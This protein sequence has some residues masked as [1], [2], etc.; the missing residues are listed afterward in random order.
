[1]TRVEAACRELIGKSVE[2]GWLS[3]FA[4]AQAI[5]ADNVVIEVHLATHETVSPER[6]DLPEMT[7]EFECAVLAGPAQEHHAS[8]RGLLPVQ[9]PGGR[10][11][12]PRRTGFL[13]ARQM[14]AVSGCKTPRSRGE[15][16]QGFVMAALPDLPLPEAVEVFDHGLKPVSRGGAKTGVTSSERH[17][18]MTRPMTSGWLCPP[19]KRTSLSN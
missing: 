1:M 6:I 14:F 19:W 9:S 12:T 5:E 10:K 4:T 7:E 2:E 3:R 8:P 17:K 18:R 11:R 15:R 13:P 16:A